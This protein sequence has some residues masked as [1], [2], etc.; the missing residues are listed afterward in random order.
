MRGDGG[1]VVLPPTPGYEGEIPPSDEL[2]DLPRWFDEAKEDERR[3]EAEQ[4]II[5]G[6]RNTTLTSLAG[7]VRDRGA[8]ED[9]IYAFIAAVNENRCKPPLPEDEVRQIARSAL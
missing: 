8:P 7:S 4:P 2:P 3:V 5:A 9:E 1:W 6:G